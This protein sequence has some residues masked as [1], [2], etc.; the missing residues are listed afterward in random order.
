MRVAATYLKSSRLS[1]TDRATAD[2]R[3]AQACSG[4][5]SRACATLYASPR[6]GA[7]L[8]ATKAQ[9]ESTAE[10]RSRHCAT[11]ALHLRLAENGRRRPQQAMAMANK[12][13][14]DGVAAGCWIEAQMLISGE[15]GRWD[16]DAGRALAN[17]AC[18]GGLP[19][20]CYE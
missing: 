20:A 2:E 15:A 19:A 9:C 8:A 4:G 11:Y 13:C 5:I 6:Q 17:K 7:R 16:V 18:K 12:V 10:D 1:K 14:E 3:L